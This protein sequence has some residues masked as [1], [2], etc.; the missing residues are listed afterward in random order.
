LS[1]IP[2]ATGTRRIR[3]GWQRRLKLEFKEGAELFK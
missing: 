3:P 1:S 2:M